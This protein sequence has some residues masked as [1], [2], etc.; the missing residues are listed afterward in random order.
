MENIVTTNK[1]V[2]VVP[3]AKLTLSLRL[4]GRREDGYHFIESEM[5]TIDLVDS[6][7]IKEGE[8]KVTYEGEY[9]INPHAKEDLVLRALNFLDVDLVVTV[10][11][12]IPPQGG[13]GGGSG[14]A[15]TV[16]RYFG[17]TDLEKAV[18]LGADVPFNIKGG[19]ARVGGIGEIVEPL[20][21]KEKTFTLLTPDVGCST[22]EVYKKW[23][24]LGG[25]KG[26]NGNDLEQAA[27]QVRP[28]LSKWR[29]KLEKHTGLKPKLAGSGSTWFVE[30]YFPGQG[31]ITARTLPSFD[32]TS[33]SEL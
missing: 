10:S 16:L 27:L 6:V 5:V 15:A 30:G 31:F 32:K 2:K 8:R 26:E 14:N 29:D 17:Y 11:K 9:P 13:L 25:P 7:F 21:Y 18:K 22:T 24:H 4:K 1:S 23:D 19:R 20:T 12:S 3:P 28:E 33:P